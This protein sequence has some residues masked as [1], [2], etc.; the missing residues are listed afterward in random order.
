MWIKLP[1]YIINMEH[2]VLIRV[3]DERVILRCDDGNEC[4]VTHRTEEKARELYETI[5][6]EYTAGTVILEVK[7]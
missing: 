5:L 6:Q 2:L 7:P 4:V 1:D 3:A